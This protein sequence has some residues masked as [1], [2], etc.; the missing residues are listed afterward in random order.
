MGVPCGG[1]FHPENLPTTICKFRDNHEVPKFRS[2]TLAAP[3]SGGHCQIFKLGFSD[4]IKWAVRIP[5]YLTCCSME[6]IVTLLKNEVDILLRLE[7]SGFPWSP[8]VVGHDL[9][10]DNTIGFPYI[11]LTWI[12]GCPLRWNNS[13]PWKR[14]DRDKVVD[15]IA[16]ITVSLISCTSVNRGFAPIFEES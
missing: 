16:N 11:V 10:F 14:S 15:Q 3:L 2:N 13:T 8:K 5:V 6:A 12:S 4:N 9:T 7:E 1:S